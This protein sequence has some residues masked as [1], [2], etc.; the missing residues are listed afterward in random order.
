MGISSLR[1]RDLREDIV[2]IAEA[3]QHINDLIGP[4]AMPGSKIRPTKE[5]L[6]AVLHWTAAASDALRR[7]AL[8]VGNSAG[9]A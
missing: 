7:L 2:R 9:Q 1:E 3:I 5:E 4:A 8:A 6:L